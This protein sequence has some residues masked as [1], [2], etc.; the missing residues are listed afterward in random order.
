M[1]GSNSQKNSTRKGTGDSE[2]EEDVNQL[3]LAALLTKGTNNKR[4]V[5]FQY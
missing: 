5:S 4:K 3:L 1:L 2:I